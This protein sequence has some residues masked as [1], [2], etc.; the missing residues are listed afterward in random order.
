MINENLVSLRIIVVAVESS[1][2]ERQVASDQMSELVVDVK[3]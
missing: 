2:A 3:A 1:L